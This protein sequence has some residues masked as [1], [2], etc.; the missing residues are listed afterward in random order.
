MKK[1][2]LIATV[3]F[4]FLNNVAYAREA[5]RLATT[6]STENS[7]LLSELLPAFTKQTQ[8]HVDVIAVGTGKALQMARSGDADVVMVHARQAENVFIAEGF[9]V[10]RRDV[11]ENDFIIVGPVKD[12]ANIRGIKS[13]LKALEK[14]A[15]KRVTFI[16]RGDQSGTHK[17]ERAIWKHAQIN[18]QGPWYKEA[19]QGMGKILLMASEMGAYTLTDRGTWL[20]YKDKL[21]LSVLN[22]GDI[23]LK[24]PYGIIAVNPALH[25][26]IQYLKAMSLIAWITSPAGQTLIDNFQKNG[27][28][29]FCPTAIKTVIA[30]E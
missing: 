14:I 20:A 23:L 28:R 21:S 24:N 8:I 26:D 13:T 2:L 6:T 30:G 16:S 17:K 15:D 7:G 25:K 3:S 27:Q 19:G 5:L 4:I 11:M 12:P 9:G 18:P 1:I 29:L 10:N 22:E